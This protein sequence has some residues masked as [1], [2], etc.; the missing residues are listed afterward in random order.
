MKGVRDAINIL[1][2]LALIGF[3]G[4]NL[5]RLAVFFLHTHQPV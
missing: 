2:S 1:I 5:F 3:I 4:M